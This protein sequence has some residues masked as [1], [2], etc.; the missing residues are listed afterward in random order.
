MKI[1]HTADL[2]LGQILYQNYDRVDE[3]SHFF[4]Q[5]K[6]WCKQYQPDA[7]L[8]SGDIFDIQQPSAST[9]KAFNEHFVELRRQ[10]PD[11]AIIVTAGNHDSASR[12]QADASVWSL[13]GMT[14]IGTAPAQQDQAGWEDKYIVRLDSGYVIAL[15]FM[16][17][18]RPETL[19][20]LL[21]VVAQEN[22]TQ[23]PVVMMGHAAVTGLDITGHDYDI[24]KL[25]T[26]DT[27][28]LGQGYDYVALGHIH[29][30]QTLGHHEDSLKQKVTYN[31]PVIRYAGSALHV[32]CDEAYPHS[33]SLVDIE[34]HGGQITIEQ[35]RI[36]EL[37]HFYVLPEDGSSYTSI[38]QVM[39]GVQQFCE[40]R[41]S[42]YFRLRVDHQTDLPANLNQM[43]YDLL[44]RTGDEVR[45]NP[46]TLWT[47]KTTTSDA[48]AESPK[49]DV[50]ELQQM[51][52]PLMFVQKIIDQ[53]PDLD[54]Q[55]V[56]EAFDLVR[57]ELLLMD[58]EEK[59][60]ATAKK[61]RKAT[62]TD[63]ENDNNPTSENN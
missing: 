26:Q 59:V 28:T 43:I 58:E 54:L 55:E 37:R 1:L 61:T 48:S 13:A 62:A 21:D 56:S 5:L 35:L 44:A 15:P 45:F 2:H 52:D 4:T 30:P 12:L 36:N 39:Q 8:V 50:P 20:H 32:S 51:T 17:S 57:Q 49:F 25:K 46:K 18:E 9:K 14:L 29:M 23:K 31:E 40:Q 27:Q 60:K 10:C 16:T 19:Q 42:G 7:L 53:L 22:T 6:A 11:M 33:V 63:D 24:G 38:D 41:G 34:R 3:H 47:G